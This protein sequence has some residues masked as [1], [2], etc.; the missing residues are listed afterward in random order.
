[1]HSIAHLMH[2]YYNAVAGEHV[3]KG[4]GIIDCCN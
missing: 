2:L 1:M 4:K 3:D